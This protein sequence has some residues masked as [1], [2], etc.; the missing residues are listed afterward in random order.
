ML[1]Q[2]CPAISKIHNSPSFA[3]LLLFL[4]SAAAAPATDQ[5]DT[6]KRPHL[7]FFMVTVVERLH[8]DRKK[9]NK[10]TTLLFFP[11]LFLLLP[12]FGGEQIINVPRPRNKRSNE[13]DMK[14]TSDAINVFFLS[15][16]D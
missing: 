15:R 13:T 11:L 2:R 8:S 3:L 10:K 9:K 14:L 1:L 6:A 4:L 5:W 7:S 12:W 16:P